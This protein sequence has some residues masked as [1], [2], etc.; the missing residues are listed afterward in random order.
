MNIEHLQTVK[1]SVSEVYT[2]LRPA[3]FMRDP[4]RYDGWVC[5]RNDSG[6]EHA[7]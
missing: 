4:K 2:V 1:A 5:R 7:L 3:R 6:R